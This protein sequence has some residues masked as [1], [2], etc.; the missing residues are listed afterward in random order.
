MRTLAT[1]FVLENKRTLLEKEDGVKAT[2]NGP[3]VTVVRR[4]LKARE[5]AF[6]FYF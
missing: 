6:I 1:L 3:E 4:R 2:A 5:E